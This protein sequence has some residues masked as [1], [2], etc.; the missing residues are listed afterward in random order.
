[1][2]WKSFL[3]GM[4]C[5]ALV[6]C[7]GAVGVGSGAVDNLASTR[8]KTNS[9]DAV[10]KAVLTVFHEK[11]F[12][13]LSQ[14]SQSIIFIKA[15]GRSADIAWSTINNPN[16]VMIRP[17]V[18]WRSTGTGEMILTCQVDVVQRDT[19]FGETVRQPIMMGKSA[20][21][22]MLNDVKRRVER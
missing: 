22:G 11:G 20:Y 5:I 6:A 18:A 3:L 17:T 10:N 1:M 12:K 19:S 4:L 9:S 2:N 13:I 15:G 21:G 8:V 7:G 14:R 16:P